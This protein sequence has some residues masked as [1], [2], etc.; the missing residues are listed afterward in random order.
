MEGL[1]LIGHLHLLGRILHLSFQ[2]LSTKY[3]PI[4]FLRLGMVP[5]VVIS[6]LEL[7]KEVLKIQDANFALGP[8][9]TMGEYNYN[10]RDI[11]FVLYCDYWK[12]MRKLCA[13]ELF[14]VKRIESFQ[15]YVFHVVMQILMSKPF[16]EYREHEAEM[17]S[18][19]KD[20]KHIVFEITEQMLQFHISEF[21]PAFMRRIDWKIQR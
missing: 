6:S 8:Y 5:A 10:F 1:P 16:F 19:G 20:F 18:K 11:G 9:L 17:S 13:T 12:S 15:A 4:V 2:T 3:G 7:V 21:V 14:T